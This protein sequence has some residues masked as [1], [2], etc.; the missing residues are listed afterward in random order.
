MIQTP[1]ASTLR[2]DE[3]S[4]KRPFN[5]LLCGSDGANGLRAELRQ[6]LERASQLSLHLIDAVERAGL[7]PEQLATRARGAVPDLVFLIL[8][9]KQPAKIVPMF[10]ALRASFV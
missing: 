8:A 10:Q 7:N 6:I 3:S 2:T 1:Q 4:G 9:V 5:V